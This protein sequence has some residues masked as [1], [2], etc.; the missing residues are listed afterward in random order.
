MFCLDNVPVEIIKSCIFDFEENYIFIIK[1]KLTYLDII[2]SLIFFHFSLS[3][4][5]LSL[6]LSIYIYI[7]IYIYILL[8]EY[9]TAIKNY[10]L[11]TMKILLELAI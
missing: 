2:R 5:A 4:P 9:R 6:S 10:Y 7:Y 8:S 1:D 11:K 3:L